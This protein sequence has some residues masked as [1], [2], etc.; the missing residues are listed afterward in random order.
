VA[1]AL[2]RVSRRRQKRPPQRPRP[3]LTGVGQ[4]HPAW[5]A[6]GGH[7]STVRTHR[8]NVISLGGRSI[9]V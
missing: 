1:G 7:S 2:H 8:T 6:C 5:A 9:P 4:K 3:K